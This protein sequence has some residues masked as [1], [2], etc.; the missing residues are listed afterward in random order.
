MAGRGWIGLVKF[1]HLTHPLPG[2]E[3]CQAPQQGRGKSCVPKHSRSR[4]A[5][6]ERRSPGRVTRARCPRLLMDTGMSSENCPQQSTFS[7][8]SC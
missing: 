7:S 2:A 4:H 8:F 1:C 6:Q 5:C 3:L